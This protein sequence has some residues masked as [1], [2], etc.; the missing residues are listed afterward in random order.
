M[1]YIKITGGKR[2]N[3]ELN[4]QGS[5]NAALPI[6]AATLLNDGESIIHN[7]PKIDDVFSALKILELFGCEIE[8]KNNGTVIIN[9]MNA[10]YA[11]IPDILIKKMRSS[12]MFAGSI[13]SRFGKC[14]LSQPG[15]CKIGERPIDMHINAFKML[16]AKVHKCGDVYNIEIDKNI[17]GNLKLP[18]PSVGV[19]ENIMLLC[20]G[21]PCDVLVDNVAREP[22]IENLAEYLNK[23]GADIYGAGTSS[24]R[25]IGRRTNQSVEHKIIPDR[26]ALCTYLM[27]TCACG[28]ECVL[29]RSNAM[30]ISKVCELI[31]NMGACIK[32]ECDRIII[33]SKLRPKGFEVLAD[34]YPCFPTDA[35]PLA[36][37]C[38]C[39]ADGTSVIKDKVF[40]ERFN[41]SKS[42]R[43]F[44]SDI[45]KGD[46]GIKIKGRN[47]LHG[48][49]VNAEELRGGASLVLMGLCAEGESY[50][51]N[52]EFIK[53][54]YSD[55][56]N[57]FYQLGGDIKLIS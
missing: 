52:T 44:G 32:Q 27:G 8:F 34:I 24:M 41:Y 49:K 22:E 53:R 45:T 18:F 6:L 5:K 3:G 13:L 1:E 56:V 20:A 40:P 9:S 2:L 28:G 17:Q 10:A 30:H 57:D 37:V 48:A 46:Y 26:I 25:I 11:D 47:K 15:G 55:I 43:E 19:T 33:N 35:Q 7:C 16:G 51:G 4:V 21:S 14:T 54:G 23:C 38:A 42:F 39:V 12:V 29:H 31:Q 50:I 36:A